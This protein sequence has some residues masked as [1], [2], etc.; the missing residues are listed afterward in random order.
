MVVNDATATGIRLGA[1]H[2]TWMARDEAA[3]LGW[4][5]TPSIVFESGRGV[6]LRDVEGREYFDCTSGMMSLPLGHCHPELTDALAQ[7]ASRFVHHSSW[8]ANTAIIEFAERLVATLPPEFGKVNFAVTGSEAN[9]VAMRMARAA[10]GRT[11]FVSALRGLHGGT[12]AMETITN[13]GGPRKRELGP[14]MTP[15][16][17]LFISVPFAY[18]P[19][20]GLDPSAPDW[21]E[22]HLAQTREQLELVSTQDVAAVILETALVAGGFIVPPPAWLRGIRELADELGALLIL[23]EAQLAPAKTG[24]FWNFEQVGVVPDI[25]TFAKGMGAGMPIC[26]AI[27]TRE[28]A[29]R[30]SGRAGVPWGGTF[31]GDPI[32]AAVALKQIEIVERDDYSARAAELGAHL[33]SR[34]DAMAAGSSVV[35][36]VRSF[37]MYAM[38]DVVTDKETRTPDPRTAEAIRVCA[39]EHG[40]VLIAVRNY[41]R[42]CPSLVATEDE[43]D[44]MTARLA[45][46]VAQVES[47]YRPDA[48]AF[49]R[50]SHSGL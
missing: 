24:S 12:L 47:G 18:R 1:D 25:V 17:G 28:V 32:G 26:G 3:V 27:A 15:T 31:T 22:R 8:Y 23:D 44:E 36:D 11:E 13:V 21:V 6:V 41:V 37:G 16:R 49:G 38:L 2:R 30:A 40:L 34:L 4:R 33:R 35:G 42:V 39:L 5:Y 46:A 45:A 7:Q 19:S 50:Q 10:T 14:L 29:E 9:E 43:L 48:S 20:Q